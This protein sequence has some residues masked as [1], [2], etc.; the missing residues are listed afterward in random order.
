LLLFANLAGL[1]PAIS[2]LRENCF[3]DS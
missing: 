2:Q 3:K 1:E